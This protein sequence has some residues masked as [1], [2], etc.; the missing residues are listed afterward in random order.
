MAATVLVVD[1]DS[2][3]CADWGALLSE[4]GYVVI[5]AR[6]GE[7][8]LTHCPRVRPDLVL[9]YDSFPDMHG[10]EL[11]RQLKADPRNCLTPIVLHSAAGDDSD[12]SK[13]V[14]AGATISGARPYPLGGTQQS[15]FYAATETLYRRTG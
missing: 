5:T 9:L 10:L 11:C 8:A 7:A 14:G 3:R 13:A 12:A 6:N 15:P 1:A 4:Q 2:G